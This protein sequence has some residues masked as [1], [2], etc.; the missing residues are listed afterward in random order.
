[1]NGAPG[2]IVVGVESQGF[3]DARDQ[4]TTLLLVD[5]PVLVT[6]SGLLAWLLIGRTLRVVVKLAE[7]ADA[8]SVSESGR[9]LSQP[10]RDDELGRLTAALNRM[11]RRLDTHYVTNLATAAETSHRLRTPLATLRAEA[12]LALSDNDP[13]SARLALRRIIDDADRLGED[14]ERLLTAAST[15]PDLRTITDAGQMLAPDWK[16]QA[17]ARQR[18]L[19]VTCAGDEMVDVSLL[20]AVVDPIVENAVDNAE[21]GAIEIVI[22]IH[23][24]TLTVTVTNSGEGIPAEMIDQLFEPWKGTAHTG[25]GLWLARQAARAVGGDVWCVL[26][27]PPRTQF[28]AHLP[29]AAS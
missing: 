26:P 11:L 21:S 14:I 7:E 24:D 1:V 18:A 13:E 10:E 3:L 20:R 2:A 27:G 8:L 6:L 17:V 12:E 9:G 25:L 15:A 29:I 5:I 22:R 4:L 23:D 16:R 19:V 28:Q